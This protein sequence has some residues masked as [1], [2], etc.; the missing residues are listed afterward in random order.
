M[1]TL[2]I[3]ALCAAGLSY[4]SILH[5]EVHPQTVWKIATGYRAESFHTENLF[6]VRLP[7]ATE[8]ALA[9]AA[10]LEAGR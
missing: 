4:V 1:K 8:N 10:S 9:A 3:A 7:Q 2:W 5:A 6:V